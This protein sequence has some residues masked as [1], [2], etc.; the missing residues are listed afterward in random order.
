MQTQWKLR[1]RDLPTKMTSTWAKQVQNKKKK[2]KKMDL[3]RNSLRSTLAGVRGRTWAMTCE[4]L[5]LVNAV[6]PCLLRVG[7]FYIHLAGLADLIEL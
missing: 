3:R 2:K 7:E 4:R 5:W 1:D 6:S